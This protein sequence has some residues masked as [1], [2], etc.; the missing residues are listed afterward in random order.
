MIAKKKVSGSKRRE[1]QKLT[2][3]QGQQFI[4]LFS[5]KEEGEGVDEPPG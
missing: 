4:K 3:K 5:R 1:R 2:E